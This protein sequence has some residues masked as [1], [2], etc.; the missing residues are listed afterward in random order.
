MVL[1][2][3][4]APSSNGSNCVAGAGAEARCRTCKAP[5]NIL[6]CLQELAKKTQ[7]THFHPQYLCYDLSLLFVY[8]GRLMY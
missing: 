6:P 8:V 3:F 5:G 4:F 2:M 1:I 7:E